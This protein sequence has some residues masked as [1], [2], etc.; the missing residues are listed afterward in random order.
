VFPIDEALPPGEYRLEIA[1]VQAG[2]AVPPE[3]TV[4]IGQINIL[5]YAPQQ[6][7]ELCW[8]EDLCLR[9]YDLQKTDKELSLFLYWQAAAPLDQSYKRFVHLIDPQDGRVLAQ[10]DGVPRDWT[11]P[12]DIWEAGEIVPDQAVLSLEGL[13]PGAYDL[14][15]GWY[16]VDGGQT[17]FACPTADCEEQTADFQQLAT[18]NI[19]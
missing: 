16:A 6:E 10:S 3:E 17:L 8:Q 7:T 18:I 15:L 11:Y 12:T 14:R 5:P 9:G 13:E 1:L 2:S 19:P 4:A